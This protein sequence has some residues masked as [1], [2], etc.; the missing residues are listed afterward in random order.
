MSPVSQKE[1]IRQAVM[2]SVQSRD[3]YTKQQVKNMLSA[4]KQAENGVKAELLRIKE[5]S[6]ISKGLEIRRSQLVGIQKEIDAITRDL[7][8]E[9]S[10]FSKRSLK[11]AFRKSFDDVVNE[12]ADMGVPSYSELSHAERLAL[13]Q[14]AFSLVD[15]K[16]LD[17]LVNYELQLLGNVTRELAEGIKNRITIGLIQGESIAKISKN[18]GGIITDPEAFRRAGKTVF[19]TAQT[20]TE[21][22]VRTETLRAYNQGRHKFYEQVGVKWVRWLSVGDKRMCPVCR[23]LDGKRF[24]LGDAPGP[25]AHPQCRCCSYADPESLGI[26]EKRSEVEDEI[27]MTV[28]AGKESDVKII[29]PDE[30]ARK[31]RKKRSQKQQIGKWVKA[32]KFEKFTLI[33]LQDIAKKWGVSTYRTKADFIRMLAPLEPK[34]DWDNIK[35]AA[36]RKLLKKQKI[37]SMKSKIELVQALKNKWVLDKLS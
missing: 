22:I 32:G 6:I 34:V 23:E 10:L 13:A 25:P 18:I 20:R 19:R 12:W 5:K 33:Q 2:R 15:R 16:A 14:D 8:K 21:T 11:G 7:K 3:L 26:K 4:L 30:I 36:L 17:F 27:A 29:S 31:A 9:M 24:K 28:I 1:R 35:G 37:G